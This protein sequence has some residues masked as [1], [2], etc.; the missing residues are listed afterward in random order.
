M[1]DLG[2]HATAVH[3]P[4]Q[5]VCRVGLG[6]VGIV[7][8]A[9]LV[10]ARAENQPVKMLDRPAAADEFRCQ[11]VE[12][13]RM[14]RLGSANPKVVRRANQSVPEVPM[15]HTVGYNARRHRMLVV[16]QPTRELQPAAGFVVNTVAATKVKRHR[17]ASRRCL[18]EREVVAPDVHGQVLDLPVLHRHRRG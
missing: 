14:R 17:H 8:G 2:L 1:D 5:R 4:E 11:P 3:A 13:F 12:Q 6:G 10:R 9:H 16:C 18:A 15:P 7:R